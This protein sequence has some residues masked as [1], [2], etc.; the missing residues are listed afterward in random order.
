MN[1]NGPQCRCVKG[2]RLKRERRC[3][4]PKVERIEKSET[5]MKSDKRA[6]LF[7]NP[8]VQ[9]NQTRSFMGQNIGPSKKNI[10]GDSTNWSKENRPGDSANAKIKRKSQRDSGFPSH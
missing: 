10:S 4:R 2:I 6:S 8:R 1:N 5:M 7:M 9:S 3:C